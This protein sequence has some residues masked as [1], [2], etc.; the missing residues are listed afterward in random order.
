MMAAEVLGLGALSGEPNP[1]F[2]QA[3]VTIPSEPDCAACTIELEHVFAIQDAEPFWLGGTLTLVR[4]SQ[5]RYHATS[6]TV[7]PG[8]IHVLN[9]R[10]QWIRSYGRQGRGPGE[11]IMTFAPV[12]FN[13]DT[14][15][16]YDIMLRRYSVWSPTLEFVRSFNGPPPDEAAI[17]TQDGHL[18]IASAVMTRE[19]I[20]WPLH[21]LDRVTGEVVKSFGSY[22]PTQPLGV[23]E[24]N[25]RRLAVSKDGRFW[26]AFLTEYRIGL[27]DGNGRQVLEVQRNVDWF[28]AHDGQVGPDGET[29][30]YIKALWEDAEGL[31]WLV[32][33]V[34]DENRR[35]NRSRL[36]DPGD[37]M[38][39]RPESALTFHGMLD[40][41]IEVIDPRKG[42]LIASRR[43]DDNLRTF[44]NGAPLHAYREQASGVPS[45]D[46]Y[47]AK[48]LRSNPVD[49]SDPTRRE[50]K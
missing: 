6:L 20:G 44:G 15:Y 3:V 5:G 25:R 23:I 37:G 33:Q 2:A 17:M 49:R 30:A 36:R 46:V 24:P 18:L 16:V 9:S 10:G 11:G 7:T 31:L 34:P 14:A 28:R 43:L 39:P 22:D 48:L 19:G 1:G 38:G 4:D 50:Q 32:I 26:A 42:T 29:G 47:R 27:W 12:A 41:V 8:E 35:A 40:T 13:V 45:Y 21:F